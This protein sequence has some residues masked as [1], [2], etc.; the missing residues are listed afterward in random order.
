VGSH[1]QPFETNVNTTNCTIMN[2]YRKGK[3][4]EEAGVPMRTTP[5][6]SSR[7]LVPPVTPFCPRLRFASWTLG[8]LVSLTLLLAGRATAQPFKTLHSFTAVSTNSA[9]VYTNSD[10]SNP[11]AGLTVVGNGGTRYGTAANGGPHGFGTVFAVNDDGT[12]FR[13]LRAFMGGDCANPW[14]GLVLSGNT[15]YGTAHYGG[16]SG[17][18][19]VF[20]VNTDG[21]GFRILHGFSD[22]DGA[23][24]NGG[25]ILSGNTLYGTT[26]HGGGWDAGTVFAVNTDGTGFRILHHFTAAALSDF[27][28]YDVFGQYFIEIYIN[29]D[30]AIPVAGLILSGNTLYG[31]ASGGGAGGNG[32]VFA[33]NTD[34]TGFTTLH[35]FDQTQNLTRHRVGGPPGGCLGGTCG[36]GSQCLV[37]GCVCRGFC[38]GGGG[39]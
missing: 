4:S 22:A 3:I 11:F 26:A 23:Y 1:T 15:L 37:G 14:T 38:S 20:A 28:G 8:P 39:A 2:T 7:I 32:T 35:S 30:G 18:G 36:P 10:G 9:G 6:P 31:T 5:A 25:L 29:A 27:Y 16:S 12:G 24:P 34:G 19:A 21:T 13:L 33:L 17:D